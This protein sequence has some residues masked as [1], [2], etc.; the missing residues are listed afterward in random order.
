MSTADPPRFDGVRCLIMGGG[1]FLGVH[2]ANALAD[3]GAVVRAFGRT[4]ADPRELSDRVQWKNGRFEDP[5]AVAEAVRGQEIVFHLLSSSVPGSPG[6]RPA[7][8]LETNVLGTL[9]FLDICNDAAVRKIVFASSGGTV[10]GQADSHPIPETAPTYPISAYGVGKLAIEK[11][12]SLYHH[13]YGLEYLAL[14]I[15]NAYGPGQSILKRQGVVAAM[16][17]RALAGKPLEI[18]GD[19]EVVRDFVHIDDV[20]SAFLWAVTYDGPHRVMNV[21]SGVGLSINQVASDIEAIAGTAELARTYRAG[22]AA[23]VPIN[24][25]DISLVT[26]ETPWR[27]RR[28]WLDGLQGTARWMTARRHASL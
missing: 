10:Y 24:I 8:D 17:D 27:P 2:L 12:L 4:P 5:V 16:L 14:R 3:Q 1:G 22:R 6:Q 9:R 28:G 18:W 23:D 26:R 21:G 13:L 19:G 11:Y 7:F 25:L 15:A 20:I